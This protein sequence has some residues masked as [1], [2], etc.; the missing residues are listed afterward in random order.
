MHSCAMSHANIL[1]IA[2]LS[3]QAGEQNVLEELTSDDLFS[4]MSSSRSQ[5][6]TP[7]RQS[8]FSNLMPK[9]ATNGGA[10]MEARTFCRLLDSIAPGQASV[11]ETELYKV[12]NALWLTSRRFLLIRL[13]RS[14]INIDD[15]WLRLDREQAADLQHQ[16]GNEVGIATDV[17]IVSA[18]SVVVDC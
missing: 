13:S 10:V 7:S 12:T 1:K 9:L 14:D 5:P 11:V 17:N 4:S 3:G 16:G 8:V 6:Q 15:I 2:F 18:T